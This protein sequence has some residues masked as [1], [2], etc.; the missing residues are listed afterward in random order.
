MMMTDPIADMLTRVRNALQARHESV[1]IPASK[2][3]IEIAKILK[4]EGFITDYK[5]EGDVKKVLTVTLKYGANNEK[6]ISGLKRISKPGL[7]VYAKVDLF[8]EY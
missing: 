6:I 4:S 2:E 3:K 1:E 5:V 8:L 7:R